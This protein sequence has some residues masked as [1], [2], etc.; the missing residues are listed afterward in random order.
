[1]AE[2]KFVRA[3]CYF[4]LTTMWGDVPLRLTNPTVI[5]AEAFAIPKS[6]RAVIYEQIE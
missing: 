1:M 5:S 4:E 6:S 2:A 3:W